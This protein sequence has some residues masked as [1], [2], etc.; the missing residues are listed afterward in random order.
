[1]KHSLMILLL[2]LTHTINAEDM[3]PDEVFVKANNAYKAEN[4]QEAI[5][6]YMS[7]IANNYCSSNLYYN[8]GNAY[9]RSN[10]IG[11]AIWAYEF[12]HKINPADED[13]IFNLE[14]ANDKTVDKISIEK[15]GIGSWL[16]KN[17]FRF[18]PN[19]WFFIS[20]TSAFIVAFLLYL[21]FIPTSHLT[22]NLSLLGVVIF[23]VLLLS[24][25]SF[26][27]V[28]KQ[29]IT[30]TSKV[31]VIKPSTKILI[32]PNETSKTSFEMHEGGQMQ[33]K[34]KKDQWYEVMLNGNN[35]WVS[36]N[37]VWAY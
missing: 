25:A 20:V 18:S 9:Y 23:G 1:M 33:I 5:N 35:G 11:E 26:S 19:F 10:E 36:Q 37:D 21:F 22:N 27:I 6:Q 29:K 15:K 8:L 31:V 32:E 16:N 34:S 7:L 13:V 2:V 4:Y 3:N 17:I 12:A 24:A 30:G 28:Q 14:F